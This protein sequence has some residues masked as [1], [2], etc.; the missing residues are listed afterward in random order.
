MNYVNLIE[1]LTEI[2]SNQAI[3]KDGLTLVYNLNE[4]D[5]DELNYTIKRVVTHAREKNVNPNEFEV[6]IDGV[7]IKILKNK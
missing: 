5:Y 4:N 2:T 6:E 7:L 3:Y 1:T